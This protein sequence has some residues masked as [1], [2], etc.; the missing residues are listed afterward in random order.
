LYDSL[1]ALRSELHNMSD[2]A[3]CKVLHQ[4]VPDLFVMWDKAI[5]QVAMTRG[6][7]RY[8]A[9]LIA[10][11]ELSRRLLDQAD[12]TRDEPEAYLQRELGYPTRKTFAKYVD[13]ANWYWTVGRHS[14][15][16]GTQ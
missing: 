11:H 6:Y 4:L 10:M 14:A 1:I 16:H 3:A 15:L 5:K 2:A 8:S 13:E 7:S 12:M 9:F